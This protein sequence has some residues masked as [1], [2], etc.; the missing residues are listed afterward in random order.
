[1]IFQKRA[2]T[3]ALNTTTIMAGIVVL[4]GFDAALAARD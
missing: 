3:A 1:M 2:A 4:F